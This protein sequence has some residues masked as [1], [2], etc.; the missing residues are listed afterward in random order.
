MLGTDG[1]HSDMI[2]SAKA[3][4]FVGQNFDNFDFDVP[5]KRLR[6]VHRYLNENNFRGDGENNLIVLDYPS[7]TD[8]NETNF[9]GHFYFGLESKY[10]SH[11]ISNG[12]LIVKDRKIQTVDEKEILRHQK[13]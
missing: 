13:Y 3:V 6:N 4:Y 9:L 5:Y 10:I 8:F 2:R 12:K 1:M 7:P 11:V